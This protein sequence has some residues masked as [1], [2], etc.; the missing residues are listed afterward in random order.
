VAGRPAALVG[1]PVEVFKYLSPK[2]PGHQRAECAGGGVADEVKDADLL[3][4][5]AQPWAGTESLYLWAEDLAEGHILEIQGRHV[6][7]GCA[8]PGGPGAGRRWAGQR[9]RHHVRRTW[10]IHKLVGVF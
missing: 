3:R 9:V 10:Y 6:G 8:D 4:D 1:G 5:D 7:D 2:V